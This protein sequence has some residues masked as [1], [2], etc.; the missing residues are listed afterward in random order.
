MQISALHGCS[1][2]KL[3]HLEVNVL[4]FFQWGTMTLTIERYLSPWNLKPVCL[5]I[6]IRA[7]W[8]SWLRFTE[9]PS[10]PPHMFSL[11]LKLPQPA[12]GLWQSRIFIATLVYMA[13]P[14]HGCSSLT[15]SSGTIRT[16][17]VGVQGYA[18]PGWQ[19]MLVLCA[20]IAVGFL[21]SV[22]FLL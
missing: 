15:L 8:P 7:T 3:S 21:K 19:W 17:Y 14:Q 18:C 13:F 5:S 11:K 6:G 12:N 1:G 2:N 16:S 4:Q 20:S 22:P 9:G 10:N